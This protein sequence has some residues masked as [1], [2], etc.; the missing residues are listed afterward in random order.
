MDI[1]NSNKKAKKFF[2]NRISGE[3]LTLEDLKNWLKITERQVRNLVYKRKIPYKKVGK[4]LR[5]EKCEIDRWLLER[6]F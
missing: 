4:F 2:D 3:L 6:S 1:N 5:F